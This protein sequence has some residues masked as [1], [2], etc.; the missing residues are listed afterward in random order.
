[1]TEGQVCV[2]L[3]DMSDN[4][5]T[6]GYVSPLRARQKEQTTGLILDAVGSLIQR[7][8]TDSVTIGEA[9]KVAQVTERTIYRHFETREGLLAAFWRREL[10]RRGGASV[11][12]PQNP[13][14]L[15]ANIVRLFTAL[16][17]DEAFVRALM[18]AP[19]SVAIRRET[20]ERRFAHM[21]AFLKN[22]APGLTQR[23]YRQTAAGITSVSSVQS[24]MFMRDNCGFT[25]RQAGEAA[26]FTVDR[27]LEGAARQ[28]DGLR[29]KD[30]AQ[31]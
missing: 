19:E 22:F 15:R 1:M 25:G 31:E 29:Q 16:D 12:A 14:E 4:E 3:T 11:V 5:K 24:W 23:E 17:K 6:S 30:A 13:A 26:A 27:I 18:T 28:A 20:N 10:E 2:I 9:A 8:G 7:S 21:V